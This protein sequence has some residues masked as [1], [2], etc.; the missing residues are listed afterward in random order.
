MGPDLVINV[1]WISLNSKI[2]HIL[3]IWI[4]F[5]ELYEI[6]IFHT[7][8]QARWPLAEALSNQPI[9]DNV[10]RLVLRNRLGKVVSA[11]FKSYE[12]EMDIQ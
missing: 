4:N 11:L 2:C 6:V 3:W 12:L 9:S 8:I 1:V 7:W 5:T 10:A